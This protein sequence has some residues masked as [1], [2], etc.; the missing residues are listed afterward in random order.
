MKSLQQIA[1]ALGGEVR[2]NQVRAPGPGHSAHDRS[3]S[4]KL[5]A[6]NPD[7][8]VVNSF[9]GD[10]PMMCRDHVKAKLGMTS[11][12]QPSRQFNGHTDPAAVMRRVKSV[13]KA[14]TPV[15]KPPATVTA[16]YEY[17]N[18]AGEVIYEVQ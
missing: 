11:T 15:Q 9:A 18:A 17:K 5:S 6:K 13:M 16:T 4:I 7:G 10:D 1:A 8:F 12:F 2:K 3:L 14:K